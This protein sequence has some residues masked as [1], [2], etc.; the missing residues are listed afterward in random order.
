MF[1]YYNTRK[2]ARIHTTTI[3]SLG[4]SCARHTALIIVDFEEQKIKYMYQIGPFLGMRIM[5]LPPLI[6][7]L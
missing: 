4:K 2:K 7:W 1:R 3:A 5:D 6:Q